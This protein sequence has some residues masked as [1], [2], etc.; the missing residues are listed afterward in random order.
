MCMLV[1][2]GSL[3][4]PSCLKTEGLLKIKANNKTEGY[5]I[6]MTLCDIMLT[7]RPDVRKS[8]MVEWSVITGVLVYYLPVQGKLIV[9]F[10]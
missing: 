4:T 9:T 1:N 3:S 7:L 6:Y 8:K 5:A 2:K 10:N